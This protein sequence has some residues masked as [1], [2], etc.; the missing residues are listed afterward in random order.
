MGGSERIITTLWSIECKFEVALG[1]TKHDLSSSAV[2]MDGTATKKAQLNGA[3]WHT[4]CC[5]DRKWNEKGHFGSQ[6]L[7]FLV[8]LY[9]IVH[10][11][12]NIIII[13][14]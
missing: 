5:L 14:Y 13:I 2:A 3:P 9:E 10:N 12:I 1:L 7:I 11:I 4:R 6:R 8:L